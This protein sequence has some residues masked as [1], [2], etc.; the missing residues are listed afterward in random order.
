MQAMQASHVAVWVL[1]T[2]SLLTAGSVTLG[3]G[4][5]APSTPGVVAQGLPG[6]AATTSGGLMTGPTS[7][8]L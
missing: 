6:A 4:T 1:I 3:W 2:L 5:L 8:R 7:Q